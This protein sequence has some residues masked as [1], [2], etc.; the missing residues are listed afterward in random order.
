MHPSIEQLQSVPVDIAKQL[1]DFAG[2]HDTGLV[3]VTGNSGTGKSVLAGSILKGWVSD[4]GG[5]GVVFQKDKEFASLS[6]AVGSNGELMF[7]PSQ[8][9]NSDVSDINA[10]GQEYLLMGDPLQSQ[11][12]FINAINLAKTR[13]VVATCSPVHFARMM[14]GHPM[15]DA[16]RD[17]AHPIEAVKYSLASTLNYEITTER[18]GDEFTTLT[19]RWSNGEP[20]TKPDLKRIIE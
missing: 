10:F 2:K 13:L 14:Y 20:L 19:T 12:H 15:P 5:V 11:S 17:T 16:E 4:H 3:L 6:G 7:C 18:N 8:K 1:L 9:G